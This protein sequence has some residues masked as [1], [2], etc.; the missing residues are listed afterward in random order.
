MVQSK[1]QLSEFFQ[2]KMS[3]SVATKLDEILKGIGDINKRMD[4]I[5]QRLVKLER[6]INDIEQASNARIA[7]IENQLTKKINGLADI[8][9]RLSILEKKEEKHQDESVMK[10]SYE[11]RFN[12]LIHGLEE[13][14]S[15]AWESRQE[16]LKTIHKFMREGLCIENP[17]RFVFADYH[18]LP[19]RPVYKNRQ[20]VDRPVI[21]KLTSAADKQEIFARLKNLKPYNE[22]RLLTNYRS[23]YVTQ[24][25]PKLFQEEK[26]QLMPFFKSARL[27]KKS[28]QWRAEHGHYVLYVNHKKVNLPTDQ[29]QCD[30]VSDSSDTEA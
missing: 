27:L 12:I 13:D 26:K 30:T 9:K 8:E 7:K 6:R 15:S 16:T 5:D 25:L 21:I 17:S 29:S 20:K 28:T 24:H 11:K 10:E 23:Q 19:Q 3:T 4:S 2:V 22:A 14:H 18:R 1:F